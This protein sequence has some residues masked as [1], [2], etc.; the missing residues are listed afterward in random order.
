MAARFLGIDDRLGS[1]AEGML[2][3]L[4]AV[5]GDPLEDISRMGDM[6]FVKKEGRIHRQP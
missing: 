1:V 2:A 3:D 6:A 4:V 5:T